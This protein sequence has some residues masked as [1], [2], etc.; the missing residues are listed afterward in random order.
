MGD[1]FTVLFKAPGGDKAE[2][3]VV[4]KMLNALDQEERKLLSKE[5]TI[6]HELHTNIVKF[7]AV[8]YL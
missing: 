7:K 6:L 3:V 5:V 1:L 8:C 2:T 4:K